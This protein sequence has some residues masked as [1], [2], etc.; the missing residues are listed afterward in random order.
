ML[1]LILGLLTIALG[2]YGVSHWT[3]DFAAFLKG[4]V[5]VSLIC[6]G[7]IAVLAGISSLRK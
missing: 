7:L 4:V 5:P 2:F 6:G 3:A 1:S